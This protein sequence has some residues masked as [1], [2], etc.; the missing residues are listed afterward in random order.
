MPD[1]HPA[2]VVPESKPSTQRVSPVR[3]NG[4]SGGKQDNS[5]IASDNDSIDSPRYGDD[6]RS[7]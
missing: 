3:S 4:V 1:T 7:V 6:D 5:D 2:H